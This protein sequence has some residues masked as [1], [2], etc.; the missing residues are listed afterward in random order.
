MLGKNE[1]EK[2]KLIKVNGESIYDGAVSIKTGLKNIG[3]IHI[4]LVKEPVDELTKEIGLILIMVTALIV[5]FVTLLSNLVA[6]YI[7]RPLSTLVRAMNDLCKGEI[8]ALPPASQPTKCWEILKCD[9]EECPVYMKEDLVCWFVDGTMCHGHALPKKLEECYKCDVYKKL[10]GNEIVHLSMAFTEFIHTLEL[11]TRE[12]RASEEKYRLLFNYD[13]NPIFAVEMNQGKILN[14]NAPALETY[15]Y[16]KEELSQKSI[17]EL[18]HEED[19]TLFW[20]E[21][22][23]PEKEYFFMPRIRA[24]TKEFRTFFV[25]VH[26][27]V[28]KFQDVGLPFLIVSTVDITR[29]LEQEAQLSLAQKELIKAERLATIGETVT[30]LAH[31]IKNILNGLRGGMYKINSGMNRDEAPLIKDGFEMAQRNVEKIS[32]LVLN[33]LSYSKER[34]PQRRLCNPNEVFLEVVESLRHVADDNNVGLR[35]SFDPNLKEADLDPRGLHRV[36]LNLVSNAIDACIYDPDRTKSFEVSMS[37]RVETNESGKDSIILEVADNGCGI[38]QDVKKKLFT[39]F[40]S[41]KKDKGTGIGLLMT[42]KI[43]K[44]HG[45]EIS[46][47]SEESEGTI[48]RVRLDMAPN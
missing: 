2:I 33:L 21:V 46:V 18:L 39:R 48:F 4:G 45:G 26:A 37:T 31:Y 40:F 20:N 22:H 14:V 1:D 10:S 32:E 7:S 13:P 34:E 3:F 25:D 15:G 29:R 47:D 44:E 23:N 28:A 41:T 42:H 8:K 38:S 19:S 36:L 30:G 27:R 43:I 35:Y 6:N 9:K 17:L 5:L 12:I 24:R 16:E 11:K